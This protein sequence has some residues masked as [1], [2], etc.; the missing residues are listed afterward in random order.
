MNIL[1][2]FLGSFHL[3]HILLEDYIAYSVEC[4]ANSNQKTYSVESKESSSDKET[5][6]F[7]VFSMT[8]LKC[9]NYKVLHE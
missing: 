5:G 6:E 8:T 4:K 1:V 9:M 7:C 2:N 3:L